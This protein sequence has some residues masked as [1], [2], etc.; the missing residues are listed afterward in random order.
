M[1]GFAASRLLVIEVLTCISNERYLGNE[2]P[3]I[4]DLAV[5][6]ADLVSPSQLSTDPIQLPSVATLPFPFLPF[7]ELRALLLVS[8]ASSRWS[9][10]DLERDAE[11]EGE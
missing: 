10:R 4:A 1:V 2:C 6:Q 7:H 5:D 9:E 3:T 11:G 8:A